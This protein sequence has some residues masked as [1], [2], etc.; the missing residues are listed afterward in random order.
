MTAFL[1]RLPAGT[2]RP[3]AGR[4][5]SPRAAVP[6]RARALLPGAGPGTPLA[7]TASCEEGCGW[8]ETGT[9]L[10]WARLYAAAERHVRTTGHA[11][12]VE[13]HPDG[14]GP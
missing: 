9:H 12:L 1:P 13:A 4:R 11:V 2:P 8:L 7:V 5:V 6:A 10:D 3:P 14:G